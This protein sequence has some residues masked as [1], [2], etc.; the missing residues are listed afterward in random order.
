MISFP[1]LNLGGNFQWH[2]LRL[3]QARNGHDVAEITGR[4]PIQVSWE[5]GTPVTFTFGDRHETQ[6]FG[7]VHTAHRVTSGQANEVV[8]TCVGPSYALS[9]GSQFTWVNTTATTVVQQITQSRG[10]A[11]D[12]T[13]TT[14][15]YEHLSQAGYTDWEL[16][17]RLAKEN[18]R[19]LYMEGATVRFLSRESILAGF[20]ATTAPTWN[21]AETHGYSGAQSEDPGTQAERTAIKAFAGVDPRLAG[22]IK[23]YGVPNKAAHGTIAGAPLF[24]DMA[25]HTP[26]HSLHEASALASSAIDMSSWKYHLKA[27][28]Y[29]NAS[30]VPG[31]VVMMQNASNMSGAWVVD[32]V[33][34]TIDENGY[35]L[36]LQLV[37]D[38]FGELPPQ[39]TNS[40]VKPPR[41]AA[42]LVLRN[43]NG[44]STSSNSKGF[45]QGNLRWQARNAQPVRPATASQARIAPRRSISG[46]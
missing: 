43:A 42:D 31:V 20:D 10:L 33:A 13:P 34:H 2:G 25:T 30:V 9:G 24:T 12:I 26:V 23:A 1:T 7:Y 28:V 5:T 35:T 38:A 11:C 15:V 19:F 27:H 36:D 18:G 4:L 39:Y 40:R 17:A 46:R 37:T 45:K 16:L 29:G 14:R 6:W 21:Y 41:P 8:L 22:V 44:G 3:H 32:S